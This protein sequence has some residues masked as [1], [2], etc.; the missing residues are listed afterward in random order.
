MTTHV[1]DFSAGDP[2]QHCLLVDKGTDAVGT[3]R[4]RLPV[5]LRLS[6]TAATCRG[7]PVRPET[8]RAALAG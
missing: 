8:G 5:P 1:L 6:A 4:A 7:N 3:T 2:D